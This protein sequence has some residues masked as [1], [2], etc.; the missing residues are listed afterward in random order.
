MRTQLFRSRSD[1]RHILVRTTQARRSG[2]EVVLRHGD[3]VV[4]GGPSRLYY[5]GVSTLKDGEYPK[6]A[7]RRVNLTFRKAL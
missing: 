6:L 2:N 7:R 3:V 1:F 5:H 4:R